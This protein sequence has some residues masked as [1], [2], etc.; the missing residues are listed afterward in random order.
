[1]R[2]SERKM[3]KFISNMSL[4]FASLTSSSSRAA[5]SASLFLFHIY[6]VRQW[7]S[8]FVRQYI[9]KHGRLNAKGQILQTTIRYEHILL[10]WCV[11]IFFS[12][13]F[14]YSFILYSISDCKMMKS[15]YLT[16]EKFKIDANIKKNTNLLV[17]IENDAIVNR[18]KEN[19]ERT[20]FFSYSSSYDSQGCWHLFLYQK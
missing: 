20:F 18:K 5:C 8:S 1:M 19:K 9:L 11:I 14:F 10:N 6:S 13:S 4:F 12:F 7:P 17:I 15:I 2:Q 16:L 3:R